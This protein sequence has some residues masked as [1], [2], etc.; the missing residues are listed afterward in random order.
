M[1]REEKLANM[2]TIIS[3]IRGGLDN[4]LVKAPKDKVDGFIDYFRGL[5]MN[6]W[7]QFN[8]VKDDL[9]IS[10]IIMGRK[11]TLQIQ[12]SEYD[13]FTYMKNVQY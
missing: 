6:V 11:V 2:F 5:S 4:I 8:K 3:L 13:S 10:I 9:L 7:C 12:E 1:E